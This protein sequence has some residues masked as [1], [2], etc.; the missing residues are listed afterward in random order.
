MIRRLTAALAVAAV[1][2]LTLSTVG[3]G[4]AGADPITDSLEALPSAVV[5]GP[6]TLEWVPSGAA[7]PI[8]YTNRTGSPQSCQ[9][10]SA[11]AGAV[12]LMQ[13]A[14]T[15]TA[16]IPPLARLLVDVGESQI[17]AGN[18]L[19]APVA[20]APGASTTWVKSLLV[21]RAYGIYS[22]CT[23]VD[24]PQTIGVVFTYYPPPG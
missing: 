2:A 20:V 5:G 4:G 19:D 21:G 11:D 22:R 14:A 18:E 3:A 13:A 6:S 17:G 16:G 12:Q 24:Q 9:F 15:A 23:Y 10:K 7:I 1:S 8:T